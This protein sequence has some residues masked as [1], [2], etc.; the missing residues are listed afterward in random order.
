MTSIFMNAIESEFMEEG[1]E[2]E[3]KIKGEKLSISCKNV[4]D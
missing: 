2:K 3:I 1:R 4:G